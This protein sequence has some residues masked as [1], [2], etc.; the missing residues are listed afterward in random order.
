[1]KIKTQTL[2][3]ALAATLLGASPIY[4]D[5]NSGLV[6]YYPFDGNANQRGQRGH[7]TGSTLDTGQKCD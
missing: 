7:S 6:A 1:M 3:I 2:I 4:A 5:L